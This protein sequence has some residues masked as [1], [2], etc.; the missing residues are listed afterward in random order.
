[1]LRCPHCG[2]DLHPYDKFCIKTG[3]PRDDN[4]FQISFNH[5]VA[6]DRSNLMVYENP[7]GEEFDCTVCDEESGPPC[8]SSPY[9]IAARGRIIGFDKNNGKFYSI[10]SKSNSSDTKRIISEALFSE[11]SDLYGFATDGNSISAINEEEVIR[12]DVDTLQ[13]WNRYTHGFEIDIEMTEPDHKCNSTLLIHKFEI[14]DLKMLLFVDSNRLFAVDITRPGSERSWQISLE[15][16]NECT[17]YRPIVLNEKIFVLSDSG[18]MLVVDPIKEEIVDKV[19]IQGRVGVPRGYE[20][21]K[22]IV[23][24]HFN[25]AENKL[26]IIKYSCKDESYTKIVLCEHPYKP[27]FSAPPILTNAYI[28]FPSPDS[29]QAFQISYHTGS[30]GSAHVLE[31]LPENWNWERT[32]VVDNTIYSLVLDGRDLISL[33]LEKY[34]TNRVFLGESNTELKNLSHTIYYQGKLFVAIGDKIHSRIIT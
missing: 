10:S 32:L 14:T 8:I 26:S 1:M 30:K 2:E 16:D 4:Y 31:M 13:I 20:R 21:K 22:I 5:E 17:F 19:V 29:Y 6:S 7:F 23:F 34:G 12:L 11:Y 15:D 18:T 27:M 33:D 25:L 24:T 28:V 3:I 9:L